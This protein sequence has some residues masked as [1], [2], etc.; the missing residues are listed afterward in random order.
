MCIWLIQKIQIK[1][2][3]LEKSDPNNS[4]ESKDKK[5]AGDEKIPPPP[6]LGNK[7]EINFMINDTLERIEYKQRQINI[8][9]QKIKAF[10]ENK[11]HI[12]WLI[13]DLEALVKCIKDCPLKWLKDFGDQIW[14]L[15]QVYAFALDDNKKEFSEGDISKI[16]NILTQMN[17]LVA[18]YQS[19]YL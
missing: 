5:D 3:F 14:E 4:N 16:N 19:K 8:I 18:T 9:E 2:L 1:K 13:H 17:L 11:I 15:E 12:N 10:T 7:L 6:P